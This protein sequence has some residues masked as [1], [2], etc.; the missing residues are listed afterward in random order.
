VKFRA[1]DEFGNF[2]SLDSNNEKIVGYDFSKD[3]NSEIRKYKEER[4]AK[5]LKDKEKFLFM[6]EDLK[7]SMLNEGV[8]KKQFFFENQEFWFEISFLLPCLEFC[9]GLI[10]MDIEENSELLLYDG[11]VP[12]NLRI[13]RVELA[14]N[15]FD[16]FTNVFGKLEVDKF[17]KFSDMFVF[18]TEISFVENLS[19]SGK[20]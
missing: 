4:I 16:K 2:H 11:K 9:V 18:N 15:Y 6:I 20:L 12:E 5:L 7:S 10:D 3:W 14:K 1:V 8:F 19:G 17:I 13:H